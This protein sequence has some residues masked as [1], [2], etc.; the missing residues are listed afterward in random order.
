M[1]TIACSGPPGLQSRAAP[2][3]KTMVAPRASEISC[4]QS[5]PIEHAGVHH[6]PSSAAPLGTT[7]Q[8]VLSHAAHDAKLPLHSGPTGPWAAA[9][10]RM[11]VDAGIM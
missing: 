9:P 3:D 2:Q 6:H 8:R 10:A 4:E 5:L 7:L 11:L 1:V